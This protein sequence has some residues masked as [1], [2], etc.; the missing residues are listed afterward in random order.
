MGPEESIAWGDVVLLASPAFL[1]PLRARIG[2]HD[3]TIRASSTWRWEFALAAR[4]TGSGDVVGRARLV[5][6]R[7]KTCL[8]REIP[9]VGHVVIGPEAPPDGGS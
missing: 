1:T 5:V 7:D 8:P 2:P 3:A 6:C 9:L 4:T